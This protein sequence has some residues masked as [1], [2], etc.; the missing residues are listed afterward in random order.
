[1]TRR[2]AV[3]MLFSLAASAGAD[4]RWVVYPGGQGS[5]QG[6]HVVLIAGD[7]EYRSEEAI[8]QLGKILATRHGCKCTVLFSQTADGVIEPTA[9]NI[10]GTA[11]L[12]AADLLILF[13]RMRD[14]PD[15]QMKPLARY[16]ESGQPIMGLR[17]ATHAFQLRKSKTFAKYDWQGNTPGYELGFGRQV[18]GETW[19]THHG[20]HA[21]Q[22]T[23]GI[24]VKEQSDHAILRGIKDGDIWGPSDVYGV[25]LPLPGDSKPLVLGQVVA[26]MKETDPPLAGAKNDPMMPIA[27][28]KTYVGEAGKPARTFCTTMGSS[29]DLQNAGYR[30]L[31]V[32]AAYW[33]LGQERAIKPDAAVDLVGKFEVTP[34][35]FGGGKKGVKP[36]DHA[37]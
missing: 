7:D 5:L 25:H 27:W 34:F 12:D 6:K 35:K 29:Q 28:T 18:F 11:A 4:D 26:G 37:L 8:P 19:H 3:G 22:S 17:T 31:L 9:G 10:P 32:N 36:A 1:M 15:E 16:I 30:R 23:R 20:H 21:H 13:T 2:W 14:L 24:L 33:C